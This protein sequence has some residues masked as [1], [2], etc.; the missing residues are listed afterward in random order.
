VSGRR[1]SRAPLRVVHVGF[2]SDIHRREPSALLD[3]WPT[4]TAVAAACTRAGVSVHV[5]Q[6]A[7][8]DELIER[9]GIAFHFVKEPAV[10]A[11]SAFRVSMPRRPRKLIERVKSLAPDVV[12]VNGL[13]HPM[14]VRQLATALRDTAL[15]V[16][17]HGTIEPRG[18]RRMAWRWAYRPIDAV[19]F[20]AREQAQPYFDAGVFRSALPVFGI[21]EGS[22][23]FN[24]GDREASRGTTGMSGDP[25]MLWTGRLDANKDPLTA[26]NAFEIAAHEL[27]DAHLWCCFGT[28]PLLDEVTERLARSPILRGRVTLLGARP[29]REMEARYRAADFFVQTSHREGSGY[30]LIEAL[31]CG[32]PPLV[33][34]IPP[35]RRMVGDAGSLT[36]VGDARALGAAMIAWAARDRLRLR[37]AARARFDQAL[38]F[39]VIGRDLRA[40]YEQLAAA[41]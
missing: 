15:I 30:S 25:C 9:D 31:A 37:S 32:T 26:L 38:T 22:S 12:H 20:T 40:A 16:Q 41:R 39:D 2:D 18:W 34:D 36:P 35:S 17:D 29:H 10:P 28:A 13:N 27:P 23:T 8:R 24:P 1:E 5:V 19:A 14:A 6:A 33:T 3:A 21:V 11:R 4:L 7:H